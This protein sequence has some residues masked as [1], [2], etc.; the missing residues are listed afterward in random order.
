MEWL[1]IE[2][3]APYMPDENGNCPGYLCYLAEGAYPENGYPYIVGNGI[4]LNNN[5][6]EFGVTHWMPLPPPPKGE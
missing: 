1:P 4:W 2:K 5:G 3:D 6:K